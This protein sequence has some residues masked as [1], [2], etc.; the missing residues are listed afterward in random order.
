MNESLFIEVL[1]KYL[2]SLK[3][4]V[5]KING[6]TKQA[7]SLF[8][9]ML[10]EEYSADMK[11]ESSSINSSIVA[12][13]VVAMDSEL[14]LKKRDALSHANGDL[15]KLGMKLS[16]GEKQISN[17]EIMK[18]RGVD[19]ANIVSKLL[20]DAV[21]CTNGV[22][23]RLEA[24][25]LSGL[26]DGVA[27]VPDADNVGVGIRVDYGYLAENKF[28]ATIK[29]GNTGYT[30][31]SDIK[32]VLKVISDNSDVTT[33]ITL[34]RETYDL[35]RNS[36]EGRELAA[37]YAGMVVLTN[38]VLPV[39]TPKRFDEAFND[40][41]GCKFLV[42]D[43][44]VRIEKNGVQ[45]SIKPWNTNSVVFLPS[46]EVGKLVYGTL[47]EETHPVDGVKYSKVNR[48]TLISK[49]SKNDPLR[50]F[51]SSQAIVL[52]V[53]ENVDQIYLLDISEAQELDVTAETDDATDSYITVWGNKYLKSEFIIAI[54]KLGTSLASNASDAVIMAAVNKLSDAKEA[55]LKAALIYYPKFSVQELNFAKGADSTGKTVTIDTKSTATITA[56][57]EAG[58]SWCTASVSGKIVTI[59]V[60]A[61]SETSAPAREADVTVSVDSK[62]AV[63][64]VKQA[65]NV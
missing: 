55:K 41:T 7:V 1:A 44:T 19:T 18:A 51:T 47:A 61:N 64:V 8:K 2:P 63:F 20:N 54:N 31:I 25:F 42:I 4:I 49:Y 52:P 34:S 3:T 40:E 48:Y 50:E 56:A 16:L 59:T 22:D 28:G 43:R 26:S 60:E 37:N 62:T 9:T 17:I 29:W 36:Q 23:E 21:R 57:V 14:P 5:E 46:E 30:P 35:I 38:S 6:K 24:I 15:P 65:A 39:P 12:A 33:A 10:R 13:D 58:N 45:K 53:I 32:R 11:W 27:L